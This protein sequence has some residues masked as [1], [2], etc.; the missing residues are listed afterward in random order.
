MAKNP[1][2]PSLESP[3]SPARFVGILGAAPT[4]IGLFLTGAVGG[5]LG[6]LVDLAKDDVNGAIARFSRM[7]ET[8]ELYVS[9]PR[10]SH[11]GILFMILLGLFLCWVYQV[12]SRPDAFIRGL[13]ALAAIGLIA[14]AADVGKRKADSQLT[15]VERTVPL[16]GSGSSGGSQ[17]DIL[18]SSGPSGALKLPLFLVTPAYA[19]SIAPLPVGEMTVFLR[20]LSD[21]AFAGTTRVT[22][23]SLAERRLV[24]LFEISTARIALAQ[25]VGRYRIDAETAGYAPVRFEIDVVEGIGGVSV[26]A[27]PAGAFGKL[28]RIVADPKTV[29]PEELEASTLKAQGIR[30]FRAKEYESAIRAYD[31]A[32]ALAPGDFEPVSFK[33]YALFRDGR[34][35]E[36]QDVLARGLAVF[37]QNPWLALNL[38]KTFCAAKQFGRANE[39]TREEPLRSNIELVSSD[40]EIRR[41]CQ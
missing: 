30:Y 2:I 14:P 41:I 25:P 31:E 3:G 32:A 16:P 38:L 40:G 20:H 13:S 12:T 33:G 11:Q 22:V 36:A 27:Q 6:A 28:Q 4:R 34:I 8:Q 39:L 23:W 35:A 9:G 37:P 19:Q 7:L 24:D 1:E 26:E 29:E 15:V 5:M 10:I 18:N 21:K 17:L